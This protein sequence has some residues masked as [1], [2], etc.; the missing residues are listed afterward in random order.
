MKKSVLTAAVAMAAT[1]SA[2]AC[3]AD[4]TIPVIVKDT[5]SA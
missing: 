1:L 5:T 2:P 3:A 4:V